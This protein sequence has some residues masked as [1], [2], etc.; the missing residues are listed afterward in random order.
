MK[1][2]SIAFVVGLLAFSS[3]SVAVDGYKGVKFGYNVNQLKAAKICSWKE[4]ADN[5]IK[6]METYY[7]ENFK[8]SG[9]STLATA[10]FLN[11]NFERLSI[12]L[13]D[14]QNVITL[15]ESLKKKYGVPSSTFTADEFNN[16][17]SNGG[18]LTIK[19]DSDTVILGM[20]RDPST[21]AD[22]AMLIYSAPS[23][24]DKLKQLEQANMEN[25]L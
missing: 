11:G 6:G 17:Q 1:V 18:S 22:T 8:F 3:A 19:F 10:I 4:Y 15:A 16:V 21:K 20:S 14:N 2:K 5:K 25:D 7:C 13:N 12:M 23:Y 24:F 9:V